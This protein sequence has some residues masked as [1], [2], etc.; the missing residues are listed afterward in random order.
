MR[1]SNITNKLLT[2]MF[3]LVL[4]GGAAAILEIFYAAKNAEHSPG[5]V[6]EEYDG[7]IFV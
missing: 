6:L 7:N 4:I 5:G 2:M 3:S 1:E